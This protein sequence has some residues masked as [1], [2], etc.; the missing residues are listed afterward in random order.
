MLHA[1]ILL[2][3]L[4]QAPAKSADHAEP[5]KVA[6]YMPSVFFVG[7]SEKAAFLLSLEQKLQDALGQKV[8][9]SFKSEAKQLSNDPLWLVDAVLA[10]LQ[11]TSQVVRCAQRDGSAFL[12]VS[13]YARRA[14]PNGFALLSNGKV[15][16]TALS[17]K[18]KDLLRYWLLLNEPSSDVIAK[19]SR[20]LRDV[21]AVL[22]SVAAGEMDGAVAL[23]A[24]YKKLEP[25][26]AELSELT[27]L[28]SVPLPVLALNTK[29]IPAGKLSKWKKILSRANLPK[30]E[31]II[32][33]WKVCDEQHLLKDLG[34]TL[35]QR[36]SPV[37]RNWVLAKL[38]PLKIDLSAL[39][40][41]PP[42]A[43]PLNPILVMP[44]RRFDD[45]PD[46]PK[47]AKKKPAVAAVP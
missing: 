26:L 19:S 47:E 16:V 17:G 9:A 8:L 5:L 11:D 37:S 2:A 39:L 31:G 1:L 23:K 15:A 42:S 14:W 18:E 46:P 30:V 4:G 34:T 10:S 27:T 41:E 43:S 36:T 28:R 38:P 7:T 6:V 12:P 32:A 35:K 29:K 40:P 22:T 25:R 3:V 45:L 33:D 44:E 20:G 21:R 13:V 24:D